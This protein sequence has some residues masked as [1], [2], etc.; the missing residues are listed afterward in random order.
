MYNFQHMIPFSLMQDVVRAL[1]RNSRLYLPPEA[2]F[3]SIHP[4]IREACKLA[5]NMSALAHP[6]DIALATDAELYDDQK[7][8]HGQS[9]HLFVCLF[10]CPCGSFPTI[11]S[12]TTHCIASI[13]GLWTN[14]S[15]PQTWLAYHHTPMICDQMLVSDWLTHSSHYVHYHSSYCFHIGTVNSSNWRSDLI[16]LL[17]ML[18]SFSTKC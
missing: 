4:F 2:T 9:I 11:I 17:S 3:S 8:V 16:S 5:W 1:K 13:L 12:T 6:L 18:Q 15:D 7:W 14:L 10:I